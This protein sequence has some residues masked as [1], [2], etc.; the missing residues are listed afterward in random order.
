MD[1]LTAERTRRA[2]RRLADDLWHASLHASDQ[3]R[4]DLSRL[5]AAVRAGHVSVHDA[6][7]TVAHLRNQLL[8]AA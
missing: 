1:E 6:Q 3:Q 2:H 7:R 8:N 4:A 5:T